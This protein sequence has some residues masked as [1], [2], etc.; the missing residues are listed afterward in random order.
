MPPVDE[1][2]IPKFPHAVT[3]TAYGRDWQKRVKDESP[4]PTV[5]LLTL[6]EPKGARSFVLPLPAS[7]N[8]KLYFPSFFP[9][10][11]QER[12]NVSSV[13]AVKMSSQSFARDEEYDSDVTGGNFSE[14]R[15]MDK[16]VAFLTKDPVIESESAM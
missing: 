14:A 4:A 11:V 13:W 2:A 8:P 1:L 12:A 16:D 10:I 6:T 15:G 9:S 7:A 3:H 5:R